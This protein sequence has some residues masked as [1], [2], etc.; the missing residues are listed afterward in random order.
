M[1]AKPPDE[2]IV[3]G[4][5]PLL[6]VHEDG[7]SRGKQIRQWPLIRRLRRLR[8]SHIPG[9]SPR[10]TEM[11]SLPASLVPLSSALD[12]Q[13]HWVDESSLC[14]FMI[15][16]LTVQRLRACCGQMIVPA[17]MAAPE[18]APC[19]ACAQRRAGRSG[20]RR[21]RSPHGS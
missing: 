9:L 10:A 14:A 20:A 21:R 18:G 12:G 4:D 8:M 19:H 17:A 2:L 6:A 5:E 16:T 3:A 15:G 7:D 11:V 1:L 13:E